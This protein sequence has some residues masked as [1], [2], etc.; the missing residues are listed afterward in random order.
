MHDNIKTWIQLVSENQLENQ[1]ELDQIAR[2]SKDPLYIT[3]IEN[4]SEAV[5]LAAMQKHWRT[6]VSQRMFSSLIQ[7]IKEPADSVQLMALTHSDD[8][9]FGGSVFEIEHIK[10]PSWNNTQIKKTILKYMLDDLTNHSGLGAVAMYNKL[11]W[12]MC[13]WPEL[14][15][16]KNNNKFRWQYHNQP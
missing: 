3:K 7:F 1:D 4:P 12:K 11:K 8:R 5:Q 2:V 14:N 9:N 13:P 16:I 15:I 10:N 6:S